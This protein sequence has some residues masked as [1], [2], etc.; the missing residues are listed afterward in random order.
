MKSMRCA[1]ARPLVRWSGAEGTRPA[2]VVTRHVESC[3]RC[4]AEGARAR[5][6]VRLASAAFVAMDLPPDGLRDAVMNATWQAAEPQRMIHRASVVAAV[7]STGVAIFLARR[8]RVSS[9]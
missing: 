8:L 9:A 4:Q 7:V 2:S 5:R 1:V 3:V 6:T